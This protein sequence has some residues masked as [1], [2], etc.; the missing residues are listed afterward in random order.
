M[1]GKLKIKIEIV[2]PLFFIKC[3]FKWKLHSNLSLSRP[4]WKIILFL[5]PSLKELFRLMVM[6]CFF[7]KALKNPLTFIYWPLV[8]MSADIYFLILKSLKKQS[9]S[10][11]CKVHCF[12]LLKEEYWRVRKLGECAIWWQVASALSTLNVHPSQSHRKTFLIKFSIKRITNILALLLTAFTAWFPSLQSLS[13][14]RIDTNNW[15]H[16][17]LFNT[18]A[19]QFLK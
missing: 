6:C 18:L 19:Q 15:H 14:H 12:P 11:T 1:K 10:F 2:I 4:S 13:Y 9:I 16:H 8:K 3:Q 17:L 7:F 5:F